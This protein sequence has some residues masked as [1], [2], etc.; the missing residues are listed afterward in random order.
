MPEVEGQG[1]FG[2]LL[3]PP[4]SRGLHLS[5]KNSA[6]D[7]IGDVQEI[8]VLGAPS[9]RSPSTSTAWRT[10]RRSRRSGR[11]MTGG[12][13]LTPAASTMSLMELRSQPRI[14]GPIC[15]AVNFLPPF[16]EVVNLFAKSIFGSLGISRHTPLMPLPDDIRKELRRR[17]CYRYHSA[18]TAERNE[19]TRAHM[20]RLRERTSPEDRAQRCRASDEEYRRNDR[21]LLAVNARAARQRAAEARLV[22]RAS[23]LAED[24]ERRDR[25]HLVSCLHVVHLALPVFLPNLDLQHISNSST[26]EASADANLQKGEGYA[27]IEYL[28]RDRNCPSILFATAHIF[29]YDICCAYRRNTAMTPAAA[30]LASPTNGA[31]SAAQDPFQ[32]QEP[33]RGQKIYLVMG[34]ECDTPG[35][36]VSW[37]SASAQWTRYPAASLKSYSVWDDAQSAWWAG[38]DRGEHRHGQDLAQAASTPLSPSRGGRI[39]SA[40]GLDSARAPPSSPRASP[41]AGR[42]A[43]PPRAAGA[44]AGSSRPPEQNAR[45]PQLRH[46]RPPKRPRAKRRENALQES[47]RDGRQRRDLV[48]EENR[49]RRTKVHL[50]LRRAKERHDILENLAIAREDGGEESDHSSD[51]CDISRSTSSLAS[52]VAARE[53]YGHEWR[54]YRTNGEH[55]KTKRPVT[56]ILEYSLDDV[57]DEGGPSFTSQSISSDARR[58]LE[59]RHQLELP[60]PLKK[61]RKSTLAFVEFGDDFEYAFEDLTAPPPMSAPPKPVKAR[62]KRYLSSAPWAWVHGRASTLA[63]ALAMAEVMG[64]YETK[65]KTKAWEASRLLA[66]TSNGPHLE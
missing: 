19:K 49:A 14:F 8:N 43:A 12:R 52:E 17:A 59:T 63:M 40:A 60:S 6:E 21:T 27:N 30:T 33:L 35:V 20:A 18:N 36:Y 38:C 37:P 39:R 48:E 57:F 41:S 64:V 51:A 28:A 34:V 55:G 65:G 4:P 9:L 50:S 23:A 32:P 62:A 11:K 25:I 26:S 24:H 16:V 7:S 3:S 1:F 22:Q 5:S 15:M 56:E 31:S 45:A 66:P 46:R 2:Q 61:K 13:A 10:P 54:Y 42:G 53:A 47:T 29:S 58:T 44:G